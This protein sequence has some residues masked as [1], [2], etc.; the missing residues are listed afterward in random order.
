MMTPRPRDF[1][2]AAKRESQ[3]GYLEELDVARS[4]IEGHQAGTLSWAWID[5]SA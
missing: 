5:F 1:I 4:R 3:L 2:S